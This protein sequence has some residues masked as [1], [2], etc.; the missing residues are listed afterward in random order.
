[1]VHNEKITEENWSSSSRG[2]QFWEE[3]N[4][5]V[6]GSETIEEFEG[7]WKAIIEKSHLKNNEWLQGRY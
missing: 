7:S 3:V 2:R 1:V 4:H 6:W 5:C